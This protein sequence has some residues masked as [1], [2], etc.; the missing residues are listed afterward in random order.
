VD[1]PAGRQI[2]QAPHTDESAAL[3]AG[4]RT[5]ATILLKH[6]PRVSRAAEDRFDVQLSGHTHGGQIFPFNFAVALLYPLGPGRHDLPGPAGARTGG[7]TVY[8]SRGTG[9]WGP[10]LRLASP[11]EVTLITLKRRA[12]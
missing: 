6:Q 9:T 4:P 1:D 7:P 11:P 3:P 12:K 10:P 8:V 2:G 5:A